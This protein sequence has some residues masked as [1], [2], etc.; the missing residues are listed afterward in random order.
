MDFLQGKKTYLLIVLAILGT[1]VAMLTGEV[2]IGGGVT[3]I[4][5]QFGIAD[6]RSLLSKIGLESLVTKYRTYVVMAGVIIATL[7]SYISGDSSILASLVALLGALGLGAFKSG[8][9]KLN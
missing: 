1:I 3:A 2:T 8:I 5:L 7:I 6:I 4:L 9:K